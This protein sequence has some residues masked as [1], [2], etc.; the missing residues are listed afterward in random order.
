[1]K[2]K[3][4][5]KSGITH[6]IAQCQD[7]Y[8]SNEAFKNAMATGKVHAMAHGHKVIVEQTIAVHYTPSSH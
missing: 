2:H 4:K 1:M 3:V 8:W 7:C 6:A 5:T